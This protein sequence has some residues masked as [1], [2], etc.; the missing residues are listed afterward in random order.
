MQSNAPCQEGI[1]ILWQIRAMGGYMEDIV[2]TIYDSRNVG[3][4]AA[5]YYN[6]RSQ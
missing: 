3:K 4:I 6:D 5:N 2:S 1:F